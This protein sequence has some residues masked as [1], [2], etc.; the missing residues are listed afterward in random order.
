VPR[1]ATLGGMTAEAVPF[2][3]PGSIDEIING[4]VFLAS[5]EASY[6]TGAELVLD[7]GLTAG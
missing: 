4:M 5:D 6:M 2:G 7:G 1:A 3:R